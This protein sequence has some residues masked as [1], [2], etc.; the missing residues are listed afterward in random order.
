M[1]KLAV[2]MMIPALAMF[3]VPAMVSADDHGYARHGIHGLYA[4][5]GFSTCNPT[6]PGIVEGDWKFNYNGTGSAHGVVRSLSVNAPPPPAASGSY[7]NFTVTFEY[8]VTRDGRITFQ[9][10]SHGLTLVSP[11]GSKSITW[12]KGPGHGAISRDGETITITCGPPVE[13]SVYQSSGTGVPP[14]GTPANCVTTA[15]G[16]RLH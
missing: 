7:M 9:Y 11:D 2:L 5:T 3:M 12:D 1:K 10:P 15:V 14:K 6:G 16:V 4:V 8:D 13:L